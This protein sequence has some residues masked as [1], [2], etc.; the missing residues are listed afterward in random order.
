M[1]VF[2]NSFSV[3]KNLNAGQAEIK[4]CVCNVGF[5]FLAAT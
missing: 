3:E 2:V 4:F 1:N 5:N